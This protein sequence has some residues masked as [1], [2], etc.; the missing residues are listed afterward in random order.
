MISENKRKVAVFILLCT[1]FFPVFA[2]NTI[3][4]VKGGSFKMGD[5]SQKDA[6]VHTVTISDVYMSQSKITIEEFL[7]ED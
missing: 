7:G 3:I 2:Q 1:C 4:L 5:A 6:P